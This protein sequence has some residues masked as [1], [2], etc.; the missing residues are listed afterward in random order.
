MLPLTFTLS[1]LQACAPTSFST[2][3]PTRTGLWF[4]REGPQSRDA[5]AEEREE[6]PGQAHAL[7]L[8]HD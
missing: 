1:H 3:R 6:F 4:R 7:I 8:T 5:V 2:T